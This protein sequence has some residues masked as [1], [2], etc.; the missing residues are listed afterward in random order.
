MS[1]NAVVFVVAL[2]VASRRHL[3]SSTAI[4]ANLIGTVVFL[5]DPRHVFLEPL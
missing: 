2:W 1:F 3:I 5:F 4:Q